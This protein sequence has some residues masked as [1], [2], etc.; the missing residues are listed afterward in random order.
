M[1]E[2]TR[3]VVLN[4]TYEPLSVIPVKRALRLILAGKAVITESDGDVIIHSE[5][6]KFP[7]PAQIRLNYYVKNMAK[8]TPS[9]LTQRNLF[10]RD[11]YRCKYCG[12]KRRDLEKPEY[13]TR[14]HIIPVTR[15]GQDKW[16]NVVTACVKCNNIKADLLLSEMEGLWF[17]VSTLVDKQ[18]AEAD[19]LLK[20]GDVDQANVMMEKSKDNE[21]TADWIDKHIAGKTAADILPISPSP[22]IVELWA[23]ANLKV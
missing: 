20:D 13:L 6:K 17:K 10:T 3:C 2:R 16:D 1:L 21:A 7:L 11:K 4:A 18:K 15:N 5:T 23:A 12:R 22:T 19:Q 14:D 9:Q 8:R